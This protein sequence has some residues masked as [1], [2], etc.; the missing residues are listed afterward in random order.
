M[1]NEQLLCQSNERHGSCKSAINNNFAG[2][3]ESCDG[4]V[5]KQC[6]IVV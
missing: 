5:N 4:V 1:N 3:G 2:N 6:R